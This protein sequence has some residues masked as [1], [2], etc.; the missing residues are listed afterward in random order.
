M[1]SQPSFLYASD[2]PVTNSAV[3]KECHYEEDEPQINIDE[4]DLIENNHNDYGNAF[5]IFNEFI[6]K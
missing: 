6:L 1:V 3:P 4:E 2:Q 5:N